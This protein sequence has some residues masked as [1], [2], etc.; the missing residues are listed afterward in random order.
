MD[1]I[2]NFDRLPHD[3]RII[4]EE[5]QYYKNMKFKHGFIPGEYDKISKA[6]R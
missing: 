6:N 1:E 5:E 4:L 2:P 3:I